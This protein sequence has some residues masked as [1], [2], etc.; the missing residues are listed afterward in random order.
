MS[1]RYSSFGTSGPCKPAAVMSPLQKCDLV[2]RA[3]PMAAPVAHDGV[4]IGVLLHGARESRC[5]EHLAFVALL[6]DC[7]DD[8]TIWRD[9]GPPSPLAPSEDWFL[10]CASSDLLIAAF[11]AAFFLRRARCCMCPTVILV[12]TFSCRSPAS[13]VISSERGHGIVAVPVQLRP[14]SVADLLADDENEMLHARLRLLNCEHV[15]HRVEVKFLVVSHKT[16]SRTRPL[17]CQRMSPWSPSRCSRHGERA[18]RR[19]ID[20]RSDDPHEV[21]LNMQ[22]RPWHLRGIT[23]MCVAQ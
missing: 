6:L 4:A 22:E 9:G 7:R 10:Q 15:Q 2:V 11:S 3:R 1:V 21:R 16:P 8:A 12:A 5:R 18:H 20:L 13:T 17:T 23:V 14:S 19:R